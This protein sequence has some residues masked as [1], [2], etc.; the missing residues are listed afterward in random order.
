MRRWNELRT[1]RLLGQVRQ[2]AKHDDPVRPPVLRLV[3]VH[4][5]ARNDVR[6]V[7]RT[8]SCGPTLV[9][10]HKGGPRRGPY[11]G[12]RGM[13]TRG[14][15]RP[16]A[17]TRAQ[18]RARSMSRVGFG[19]ARNPRLG[20]A[21]FVRFGRPVFEWVWLWPKPGTD[22]RRWV[23]SLDK[24]ATRGLGKLKSSPPEGLVNCKVFGRAPPKASLAIT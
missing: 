13:P 15:G 9:E 7:P 22:P 4:A 18:R 23:S 14:T 21:G 17:Q 6:T 5:Y 12:A 3:K 24:P 19:F 10:S 20:F 2:R 1:P 8:A 11:F 16:E